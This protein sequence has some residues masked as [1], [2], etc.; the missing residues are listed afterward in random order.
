MVREK[1]QEFNPSYFECSE[2]YRFR[3]DK[4]IGYIGHEV[5]KD[6]CV[7]TNLGTKNIITMYPI[8]LSNEF[9]NEGFTINEELTKKRQRWINQ[10]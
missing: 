9:D 10:G 5:T 7:V 6:I 2:M 3:L 8:Q 4:K 1:I